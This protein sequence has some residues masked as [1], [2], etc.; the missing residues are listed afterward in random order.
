MQKIKNVIKAMCEIY[1]KKLSEAAIVL[2]L[3]DLSV[4]SE[5]QLLDAFKRCRLE[6]KHFPTISD[7]KDRINDGHLSPN[8][9]WAMIP[10][11]ENDSV[12]WT[13]E[14]KEAYFTA[15][16]IILSGDFIAARVTFLEKY[17]NLIFE[18]RA[19][20]K[21]A[22]YELSLGLDKNKRQE[23]VCEAI[24]QGCISPEKAKLLLP[25]LSQEETKQILGNIL[26]QLPNALL[27]K[28][29]ERE[30]KDE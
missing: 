27:L 20:N 11:N 30:I 18:A 13:Q 21:K 23:V 19:N 28:E 9:A 16:P 26:K 10:L 15:R 14:M 1:D 17:K 6:L 8:E 29:I 22:K 5:N 7:I 12:C 4:Y 25:D 3:V 2:F 24:K